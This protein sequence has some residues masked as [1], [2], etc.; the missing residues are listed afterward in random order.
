MTVVYLT[1]QLTQIRPTNADVQL[2]KHWEGYQVR[3][4]LTV[5]ITKQ[6]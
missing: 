6:R 2:R 5:K 1:P 3:C 4:F